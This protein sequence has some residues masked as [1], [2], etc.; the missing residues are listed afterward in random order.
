MKDINQV[1]EKTARDLGL[2]E[3]LV[4]DVI[5]F[6]YKDIR[7]KLQHKQ[8]VILNLGGLGLIRF[9]AARTGA[10][11]KMRSKSILDHKEMLCNPEV[12]T[13]TEETCHRFITQATEDIQLCYDLYQEFHERTKDLNAYHRTLYRAK[14]DLEEL[15]SFQEHALTLPKGFQESPVPEDDL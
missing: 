12:R 6:Y 15:Q 14:A 11:I 8:G 10:Y 9:H 1:I 2:S 5:R 4:N 13:R 3:D 7:H